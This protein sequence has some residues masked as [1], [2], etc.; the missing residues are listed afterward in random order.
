M[1]VLRN[2]KIRAAI[3]LQI[4]IAGLLFLMI[5]PNLVFAD[6]CKNAANELRASFEVT[7]GR[8]GIWGFMEQ[9]SSLKGDSMI[10]F[11]VDGKLQ[12]IIV[13]F[14]ARCIKSKQSSKESFQ[15]VDSII[16]EARMI[17]NL[18]PGRDPVKKIMA[19]ING[20]HTSLNKMIKEFEA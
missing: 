3:C 16:S 13:L 20:L 11:Q 4:G 7:Q 12:R 8:G 19:R 6:A 14:E 10:G 1:N 9:S 17:F 18:R 5:S 15:K 2:D